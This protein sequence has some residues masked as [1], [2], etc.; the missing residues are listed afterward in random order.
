MLR[1]SIRRPEYLGMV[2]AETRRPRFVIR[3]A[4]KTFLLRVILFFVV[5]ALCIGIVIPYDDSRLAYLLDAGVSTG[6]AS[7]YVISM[8]RLG[9]AG[10]GSVV[11]AGIMLSLVSAGNALLFSA[12]RTLYG[13]ASDGKA[14][15]VFAH[16]NKKGIP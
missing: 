5:G 16:V 9:V 7:P 12:T 2:A 8:Q 10:L 11:N 15:S 1:H 13:L 4:Y 14:P 6:A 3:R